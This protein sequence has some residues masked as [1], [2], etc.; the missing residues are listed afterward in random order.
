MKRQNLK[1]SFAMA[2]LLALV[3]PILA[4]CGGTAALAV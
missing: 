2:L 1:S 3:I 4:A